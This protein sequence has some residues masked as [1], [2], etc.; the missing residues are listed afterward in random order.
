[1][2]SRL[3]FIRRVFRLLMGRRLPVTRGALTVPG[4]HGR[5]RIHRDRWGIPMIE[6]DD[7]RDGPFAV[8]FCQAQDRSHH[9]GHPAGYAD[10]PAA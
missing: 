7:R 4:L 3:S 8:G 1:M 6:A 2:N 9:A 5:V 10:W